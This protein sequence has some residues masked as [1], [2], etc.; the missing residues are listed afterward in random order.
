MEINFE[1][2]FFGV[3][4]EGGCITLWLGQALTSESLP[5][6]THPKLKCAPGPVNLRSPG[7][8]L[9]AEFWG[10]GAVK[11]AGL[12]GVRLGFSWADFLVK[13]CASRT[14]QRETPRGRVIF[15]KRKCAPGIR[16]LEI[17]RGRSRSQIRGGV[18]QASGGSCLDFPGSHFRSTNVTRGFVDLKAL[19]GGWVWVWVWVCV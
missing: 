8:G 12:R 4:S 18:G 6:G 7:E 13:K 5:R 10:S 3:R 14:R 17:P 15:P 16:Q 11:G 1:F 9:G 2:P 19:G